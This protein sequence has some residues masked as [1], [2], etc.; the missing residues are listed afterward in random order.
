MKMP[1]N[2]GANHAVQF[3]SNLCL[4][5]DRL[6][7]PVRLERF[8]DQILRTLFSTDRQGR[9]LINRSLL[10]L[11]RKQSKTWLAACCV[12]LWLLGLGKKGQCCLSIANDREQAAILFSTCALICKQLGL[13]E[14]GIVGIHE[15]TKRITVPS[16]SS[17]YQSLSTEANTKTGYRPN[18]VVVDEYQDI[19]DSV[20]VKN[21]TTGFG[22]ATDYL[23]LFISTGGTNKFKP[24]YAEYEYA[25]KVQSGEIKNPHYAAFIWEAPV[26]ADIYD[27]AVWA[28]AMPAWNSFLNQDFIR[29]EFE[30]AR[31]L[32]AKE[33][34]CRQYYLN[35]WLFGSTVRWLTDQDWMANSAKPLHDAEFY[36]AACDLASVVD[37]SSVVLFGRNSAGTYDVIPFVWVCEAQVERR[38]S[39]EYDY[40]RWAD[41]GFLR[42]TPGNAQ[43]QEMILRELVAILRKYNVTKL[44]I[45]RYGTQWFGPKLLELDLPAVEFG[46]GFVSMSQPLKEIERLTLNKSL[47]HGGHPVLRW[48]ASNARL[49]MDKSE[50]Y[51]IVKP[52]RE[53][54]VDAMVALAMAVGVYPFSGQAGQSVYESRGI[55][56]LGS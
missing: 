56:T 30:L 31:H 45:D 39:A 26:D 38:K 19:S 33:A 51:R 11:P 13:D 16:K 37:T 28:A 24:A 54:K 6:G 55:L 1:K 25:K 17:F 3:V 5:G 14:A 7:E 4:V 43:D 29:S 46:Q 47:A 40:K 41:Q 27:E 32:P 21:L 44:A 22:T 2:A 23:T 53:S 20:L 42:V 10:F 49:E 34:E 15:S 48:M 18:M 8:Q 9:R 12:L 35:Q 50:N 52:D 36:T